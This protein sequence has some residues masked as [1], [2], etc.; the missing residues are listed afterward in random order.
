MTPA[1]S[2]T[3][4]RK[5]ARTGSA[6]KRAGDATNIATTAKIAKIAKAAKAAKGKSTPAA[7][8][9][10]AARLA[11]IGLH[12]DQ[13]LILHLP[14]RY[15]D[16][17]RVVPIATA[18]IGQYAQVEGVVRSCDVQ[19]RPRRQLVVRL[20]DDSG[21]MFMRFLNFYGS[22]VK[23]LAAG[24]R[25]RVRGEM[26]DG[27]L[28]R[29]MVHPRYQSVAVGTAL[30][31]R[32]T[33]VY[34][35]GEG[36]SQTIL[37]RLIKQ[38]LTRVPL[39]DTLP[40]TLRKRYGLWDFGAAVSFL[41]H[42]DPQASE[43]ELLE[44][45]HPAWERV[46]FD[47]LL[48]QQLSL[49]RAQIARRNRGAPPMTLEGPLTQRLLKSLPFALTGAQQRVLREI[50]QDLCQPH[51]MQRLLQGDV[52]SGKTVIAALAALQAIDNGYQAA[53]MAPTEILAEQHFSKLSEW[54]EQLGV[55]VAWLTG[56]MK[57]KDRAAACARIASGAARLVIGTH[58]LI[59]EGVDFERLGLVIVD[60]QHRFGVAQRLA[61]RAKSVGRLGHPA[62][63][64]ASGAEDDGAEDDDRHASFQPHQL[65]MS[66]TP[67]PRTLAMTYYADLDVSTLDE[68]PPGRTPVATRLIDSD[69]RAIVI[70]KM[71]AALRDGQQAY[72]VCPLVEESEAL[73]LQTAVHTHAELSAMLTDVTVGLVHGR[74][75]TSDKASVMQ[76]FKDGTIRLLVSTTVIEVGVDVPNASLMVI[77]HAERFGLSQLHQLRGR[78]GRGAARST[79]LLLYQTPLSSMA[80]ERL[81]IM[82]ESNDGFDIARR[83]LDL[84]GPGEFL[85]QRQSGA[86]L[87]R[88]S[89]LR[90]DVV[91]VERAREAAVWL[92]GQDPAAVDCHLARWM[93]HREDFL[94][95]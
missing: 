71:H 31:D 29:E 3:G 40:E 32:L 66:A 19:F 47:E 8:V 92:M 90:T 6:S 88:F 55:S 81:R 41:H 58:A 61:L 30:P 49:R 24:V 16:E 28:G 46:K 37:R 73:Q 67:I 38:A 48:A 89:D 1:G 2:R 34:P 14:M 22:Q 39:P 56:S 70:D 33:P 26:R 4:P 21:S 52:G 76:A 69:R 36:V 83:D 53:L 86:A 94:K 11:R 13:D 60:E 72:W 35:A 20:E 75:T 84:R 68:L 7:P 23:A 63:S 51:P 65:M 64:L 82:R 9:G 74:M 80:R 18:W 44:R 12:N 93:G 10:Q 57:K 79:C 42:P 91:L 5:G 27:F 59:Q 95:T 43:A 50:A 78:V 15:E 17:T 25:L 85:G 62:P 87:L 54:I 45:S 77:E